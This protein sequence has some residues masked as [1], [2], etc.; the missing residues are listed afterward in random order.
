MSYH[1][2]FPN[3][4]AVSS[5]DAGSRALLLALIAAL[6]ICEPAFAHVEEG[7]ANGLVSGLLHPIMGPD[8]LVAMVAVG[9]WGA[10]LG[11]PAIWVLPIVFPVV[12]AVGGLL[13]VFGVPLPFIEVGIAVSALLLGLAVAA[14]FRAGL[15]VTAVLVGVFAI[16][17]GHAH[18]T[19]LPSSAN[20]LSYGIGFVISTGL[21]HLAGILIGALTQWPSG[22]VAVRA[23]GALVAMTGAYYL[24][25]ATGLLA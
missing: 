3:P 5:G 21:L 14:S 12:M 15:V 24:A 23:C 1:K 10:Q 18:G 19:E 22:A 25:L 9:M 17:H 2:R 8:H 4:L 13:G 20:A 7:S 11:A 6:A 16:F